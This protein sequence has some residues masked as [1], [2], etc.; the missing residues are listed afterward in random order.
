MIYILLQHVPVIVTQS[1]KS[2]LVN[3]ALCFSVKEKGAEGC[4]DLLDAFQACIKT[5]SEGS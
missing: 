3:V 2:V 5:L 4:K 1:G